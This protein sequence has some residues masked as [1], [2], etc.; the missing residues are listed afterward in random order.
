MA[1]PK[2]KEPE[3]KLATVAQASLNTIVAPDGQVFE[4][5]KSVTAPLLQQKEG[6]VV[7]VEF[8]TPI[9]LGKE[10][11]LKEGVKKDKETPYIARVRSLMD[12]EPTRQYDF[13]LSAVCKSELEDA[14]PNASY[15]G[16]RFRISKS[17]DKVIG[18]RYFAYAID[19][20]A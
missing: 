16:K 4:I 19:E 13:I 9:A 1:E 20:L 10:I 6:T 7:L 15:V 12:P 11:K 8:L 5:K 14:Y 2:N 3:T 18:K 17:P